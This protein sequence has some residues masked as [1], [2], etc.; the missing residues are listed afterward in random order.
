MSEELRSGPEAEARE[1]GCR[2]LFSLPP[3][4]STLVRNACGSEERGL[5][6]RPAEAVSATRHWDPMD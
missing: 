6:W 5:T 3:S 1:R 4:D 2:G